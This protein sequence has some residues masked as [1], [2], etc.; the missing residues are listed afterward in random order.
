MDK[1]SGALGG[2]ARWV[3]SGLMICTKPSAFVTHDWMLISQTALPYILNGVDPEHPARLQCV[4]NLQHAVKLILEVESP[5]DVENRGELKA[6]KELILEAICEYERQTPSACKALCFHTFT[7]VA[8]FIHRWGSARNLWAYFGERCMGW[9]VRF[10]HNR[11]LV[12]E[13]IVNAY[14]RQSII[15][16]C[17]NNDLR[18]TLANMEDA[19]ITLP[20]GSMFRLASSIEEAKRALPGAYEVDVRESRRN[21]KVL[22]EADIDADLKIQLRRICARLNFPVPD[23]TLGLKTMTKGMPT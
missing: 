12:V 2:E 3:R 17:P 9:L 23:F 20:L 5:S 4:L 16:A 19:N 1:R 14:A 18:Q 13:N 10:V 11:D 15:L 22:Q 7:H 6:L 8:D 21:T